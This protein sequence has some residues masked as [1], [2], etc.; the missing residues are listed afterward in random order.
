VFLPS[1]GLRVGEQT[2]LIKRVKTPP[3]EHRRRDN[4]E[5]ERGKTVLEMRKTV[6]ERQGRVGKTLCGYQRKKKYEQTPGGKCA[7]RLLEGQ[8]IGITG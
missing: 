7:D 6:K 2:D 1:R 4:G 3:L 5:I 8:E